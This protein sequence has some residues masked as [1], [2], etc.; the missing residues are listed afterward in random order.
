[1]RFRDGRRTWVAQIRVHGAT[2][3]LSLGDVR[4]IELEAARA[5]ARKFFAEATLGKDPAKA[6]AEARAKAAVTVGGVIEKYLAARKPAVRASTHGHIDRYLRRYFKQLHGYPIGAVTRRDIAIAITSIAEERGKVSAARARSALSAFFS[7]ALRE[8]LAGESNPV[9]HTNVPSDEKP[10]ERTL[11]PAEIKA[12]WQVLPNNEFGQ[13]VRLLFY[14]ACR[15]Q[16]IGSLEWS[17]INFDKALVT[18]PA[19]KMKGDREHK[20]PLIP[21]AIEILRSIPRRGGNPFVFGSGERGFAGWSY[22]HR[23]L[24]SCLRSMAH[25]TDWTLHDVRRSI[26]SELGEL[27]VEPWVGEQILAHHR[28]GIEGIYNHAKLERQMRHALELWAD[29]L[30]TIVEDVETNVV[31]IRA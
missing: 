30:R 13:I 31:A 9:E 6:R 3:R 14:T 1:I 15:R 22:Y 19:H 5:A 18:I 8:G 11:A 25:P 12:I 7:W 23:H 16:E 2:R 21:E 29:R 27:G 24:C 28:G 17:E 10:R 4:R 20:L 26:R